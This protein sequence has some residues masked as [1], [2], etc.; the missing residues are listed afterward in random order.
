LLVLGL[1]LRALCLLLLLFVPLL[2]PPM[3][4]FDCFALTYFL[5]FLLPPGAG[6]LLF[7]ERGG[8]VD[9]VFEGHVSCPVLA[10]W[11]WCRG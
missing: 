8:D 3:K 2:L 11:V 7:L 1:L 6:M 4:E 10:W 9:E 5:L